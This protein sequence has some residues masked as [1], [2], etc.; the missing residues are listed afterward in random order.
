MIILVFYLEHGWQVRILFVCQ[1]GNDRYLL[2]IM[3]FSPPLRMLLD[4]NITLQLK[5][6]GLKVLRGNFK[7]KRMNTLSHE[8]RED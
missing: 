1:N 8:W 5:E 6:S 7:Q 3:L 2:Q 4:Y